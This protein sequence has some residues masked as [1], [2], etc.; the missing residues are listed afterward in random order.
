MKPKEQS[1]KNLPSAWVSLIPF[2]FLSAILFVVIRI[3][4]GNEPSLHLVNRFG[5]VHEGTLRQAILAPSGIVYDDCVFAMQRAEYET[6]YG[7]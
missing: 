7:K 4:G 5:F 2:V 6:K 3:F 1:T